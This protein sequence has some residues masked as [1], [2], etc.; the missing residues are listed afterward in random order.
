M[1]KWKIGQT[2][3][4]ELLDHANETQGN[5]IA[6]NITESQNKVWIKMLEN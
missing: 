2:Y 4:W 3:G 6:W 1:I 5:P